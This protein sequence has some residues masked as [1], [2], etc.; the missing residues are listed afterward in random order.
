MKDSLLGLQSGPCSVMKRQKHSLQ[1][2]Q[3]LGRASNV[4]PILVGNLMFYS[5]SG[6]VDVICP[7]MDR[8]VVKMSADTQFQVSVI[9][10]EYKL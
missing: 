9:L 7:H 8:F 4:K 10:Q 6:K 1:K 5:S 2:L 3:H